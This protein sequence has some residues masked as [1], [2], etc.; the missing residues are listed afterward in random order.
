MNKT[1]HK[2]FPPLDGQQKKRAAG[3]SSYLID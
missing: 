2:K 3:G 1:K